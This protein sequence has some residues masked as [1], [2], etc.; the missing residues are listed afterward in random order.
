MAAM[1]GSHSK[2]ARIRTAGK[3]RSPLVLGH[4]SQHAQA[5]PRA[6][7]CARVSALEQ[8]TLRCRS[9]NSLGVTKTEPRLSLLETPVGK[10]REP[11]S[12]TVGA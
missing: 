12:Q 3:T 10:A 11:Q 5:E 1:D 2:M 7:L 6:V 9:A 8:W 4:Y